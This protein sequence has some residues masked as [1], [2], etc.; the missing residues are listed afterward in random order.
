MRGWPIA[1][2]VS[3]QNRHNFRPLA[4]FLSSNMRTEATG[5]LW[6]SCPPNDYVIEICDIPIR[7]R[8]DFTILWGAGTCVSFERAV[9][10]A[11]MPTEKRLSAFALSGDLLIKGRYG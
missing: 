1:V 7:I 2:E 4:R 5:S 9:C 8:N 3:K 10:A 11:G 6:L